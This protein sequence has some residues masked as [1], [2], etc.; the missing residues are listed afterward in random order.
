M[1][2]TFLVLIENRKSKT[3]EVHDENKLTK[4]TVSKLKVPVS[5]EE[6]PAHSHILFGECVRLTKDNKKYCHFPLYLLNPTPSLNVLS[7][8]KFNN[9]NHL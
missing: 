7:K 5:N 9:T 6:S 4:F 1:L 2:R 8:F 3:E